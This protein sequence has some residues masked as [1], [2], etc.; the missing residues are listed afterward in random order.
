MMSTEENNNTDIVK[1]SI[2]TGK[3][4]TLVPVCSATFYN[5]NMDIRLLYDDTY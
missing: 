2:N 4:C 5:A 3:S 1:D